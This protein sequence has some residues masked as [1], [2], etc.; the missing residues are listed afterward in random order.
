MVS[1]SFV[2]LAFMLKLLENPFQKC[3]KEREW[4]FLEG[5]CILMFGGQ[6]QWN[7]REGGDTM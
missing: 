5:K 4:M 2:H 7:P 1:H 3:E 6:H